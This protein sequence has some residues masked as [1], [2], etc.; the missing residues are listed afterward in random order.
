VVTGMVVASLPVAIPLYICMA[1][2]GNLPKC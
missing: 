1:V 2:T